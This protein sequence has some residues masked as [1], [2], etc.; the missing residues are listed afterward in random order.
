MHREE[1][2][3]DVHTVEKTKKIKWRNRIL[4]FHFIDI[5]AKGPTLFEGPFGRSRGP[6][7]D[8]RGGEETGSG[9]G[10]AGRPPDGGR[11]SMLEA[12]AEEAGRPIPR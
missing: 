9:R 12:G 11:G 1:V 8:G 5:A 6:G 2:C 10:G 3:C 7:R 4:C